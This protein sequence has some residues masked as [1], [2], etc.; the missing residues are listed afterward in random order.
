MQQEERV[1]EQAGLLPPN[2]ENRTYL[3]PLIF[4]VPHQNKTAIFNVT[5]N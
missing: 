5:L 4:I 3:L 2:L 1:L